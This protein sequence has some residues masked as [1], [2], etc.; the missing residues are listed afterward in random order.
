[1][2]KTK[3]PSS[4][5]ARHDGPLTLPA[6]MTYMDA[7]SVLHERIEWEG[8]A[9]TIGRDFARTLEEVCYAVATVYKRRY[10]YVPTEDGEAHAL[11]LDL[12]D[13]TTCRVTA[14][15]FAVPDA[16]RATLEVDGQRGRVGASVSITTYNRHLAIAEELLNEI[17]A[18]V[19]VTSLYRGQAL[20]YVNNRL[21][22]MRSAGAPPSSLV[23][24]KAVRDAI[25]VNVFTPI[26]EWKRLP[27]LGLS[28]RRGVL[29][30]GTYGTGKTLTA[31]V[32]ATLARDAGVTFIYAQGVDSAGFATLYDVAA[33]YG[34]AVIFV[35]DIDALAR[36]ARDEDMN[37]L[38]NT[39]DGVNTKSA[40]VMIVLT[41]NTPEA[42]HPAFLR[43]GRL[44]A[45]ILLEPPDAEAATCLVRH[46]AGSRLPA[47]ESLAE[48]GAKLAGQIPAVIAEVVRRAQLAALY[49]GEP[50]TLR[51]A[52]LLIAANDMR[53]QLEL[54]N[55]NR[56]QAGDVFDTFA[57]TLRDTADA[58]R[59]VRDRLEA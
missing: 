32:A 18:E 6:K 16:E 27:R 31:S 13:G 37:V 59:A 30:A 28:F 7:I 46:Y 21:S 9:S 47:G 36:G 55:G 5:I 25:E 48:V 1:M 34:P 41:T 24:S 19:V 4:E 50:D 58:V 11:V 33:T 54:L 56:A 53:L 10:G 15:K 45:V 20:V 14:G 52:D 43:P 12:P 8:D 51:A 49:R 23:F 38:L 44:D 17:A 3:K 22:F 2:G 40:N 39:L 42:I 57:H 29:L 26:R 35:E